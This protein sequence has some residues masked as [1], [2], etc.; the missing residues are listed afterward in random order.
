MRRGS[1][2]S[3]VASYRQ[4]YVSRAGGAREPLF[5]GAL[6]AL[7]RLRVRDDTI[8]AV[9][10]GKGYPGALTLLTAHGILDWFNSV[11]T[12][13]HNRGKPDPQMIETAM[14]K[15]GATA[16]QT[17]MIGDTSH[18][19]KMAKAAGVGAI[20]VAWGYHATAELDAAGADIVITRFDQL[21]AAIDKLLG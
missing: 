15:A 9:A 1:T 3:L 6:P 12:P 5:N 4:Q 18:D 2:R 20:G 21:D 7:E 14:S 13:T 16:P 19:M 17:V 10:T 11:E 8:L